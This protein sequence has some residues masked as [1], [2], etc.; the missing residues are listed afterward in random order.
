MLKIVNY[1]DSIA[2][3]YVDEYLKVKYY[4]LLYQKLGEAVDKYI[5]G[6]LWVLDVGAGTGFWSLYMKKRGARVVSLDISKE[7][8]RLCK[9]ED[10]LVSDAAFLPSAVEKF[11]AVTALG[12][13]YNHIEDVPTAFRKVSSVLKKGGIFIT[14][15]DNAVC[16]DML[17]EYILFQGLGKLFQA[18]KKGVV[19]GSWES[20]DGEI[21]LNYY[22]YFYVKN[23]LRQA[24]LRLVE[25]RPI[26]LLPPIPT[27]LLQ[28]KFT[29]FFEKLDVLKKLAPLATTI[30][31]I[32]TKA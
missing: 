9:C 29:K 32:A 2:P 12:S 24:G 15:I 30:I 26:Y 8:I 6:G 31:Y 10:K 17:Y 13:V 27:R 5:K 23:A 1:Y 11:D 19:K 22:S 16:L 21:P 25:A 3:R 28:R 7:S 4:R 18:L 14:D 20:I